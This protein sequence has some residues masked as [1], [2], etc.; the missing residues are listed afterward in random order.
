MYMHLQRSLSTACAASLIDTRLYINSINA[1]TVRDCAPKCTPLAAMAASEVAHFLRS[2]LFSLKKRTRACEGGGVR[3]PAGD[4]VI[5]PTSR[6]TGRTHSPDLPF[7][8]LCYTVREKKDYLFYVLQTLLII[9][10]WL[11]RTCFA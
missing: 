11:Q 10:K 8:N 6:E 1:C 3:Q 4:G 2:L 9:N 5:T 7:S